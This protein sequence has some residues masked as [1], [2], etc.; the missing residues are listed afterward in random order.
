VGKTANA[1]SG[2]TEIKLSNGVMVTLKKTDFKNDEIVMSAGRFG[3]KNEYPVKDKYN[4]EYAVQIASTMGFGTFSPV[5]LR[6]RLQERQLLPMM[7]LQAPKMVLV[8]AVL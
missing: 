1:V 5:D 6:R 3:G 4:A 7:F 2:A 8:A